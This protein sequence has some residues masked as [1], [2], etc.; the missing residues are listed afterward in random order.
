MAPAIATAEPPITRLARWYRK[1]GNLPI[2]RIVIHDEEHPVSNRSAE[3][4]AAMFATTSRKASAHYVIDA[5]SEQHCVPDGSVAYHAPPNPH[6]IGLERDG[7]AAFT[8]AQWLAP[9]ASLAGLK[10]ASRTAEL[11]VRHD[12]PPQWLTV[13]QVRRGE[14]GI[15]GHIDVSHAFGQTDHSDPGA[16]FPRDEF[17]ACVTHAYGQLTGEETPVP[18][19][20]Y[21]PTHPALIVYQGSPEEVLLRH[22]L[23]GATKQFEGQPLA[24]FQIIAIPKDHSW[25]PTPLPPHSVGIGTH[26]PGWGQIAGNDRFDTLHQ[27]LAFLGLG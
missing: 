3:G 5:D 13:E 11:C 8:R 7:Y 27:A 18:P 2:D 19:P 23:G 14:R 17:M 9:D 25:L 6:S 12:V 24:R 4:V 15:C 1:G 10:Q 22:Y 16:G 21:D 26:V 20:M